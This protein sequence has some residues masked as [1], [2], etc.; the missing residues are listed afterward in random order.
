[1]LL[2]LDNCC[3]NRPFDDQKQL[4]IHLETEA[5]LYIQQKIMDNTYALAWSYVLDYENGRNPFPERRKC[6][7]KW[8][9]L[10]RT[11]CQEEEPILLLA[12]TYQRNG[13]KAIDALHVACAVC[14]KCDY[15]ISTDAK[16]LNKKIPEIA[17][18]DPIEFIRKEGSL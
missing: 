11:D 18:I 17:A 15:F 9:S 5:K 12:E 6:I 4:R 16:L 14:L 13:L 2:Y 7:G 10:A 8:K 3:F 1:M